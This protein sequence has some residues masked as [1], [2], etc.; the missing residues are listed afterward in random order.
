MQEAV[1]GDVESEASKAKEG[2]EEGG[3]QDEKGE[4]NN[5]LSSGAHSRGDSD[6]QSARVRESPQTTFRVVCSVR[7][8]E[9]GFASRKEATE[10]DPKIL[11]FVAVTRWPK[12]REELSSLHHDSDSSIRDTTLSKNPMRYRVYDARFSLPVSPSLSSSLCRNE[13]NHRIEFL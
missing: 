3:G 11:L 7:S 9:A 2:E 12:R 13:R 4:R 8:A 10:R 1:S 6:W 5:T